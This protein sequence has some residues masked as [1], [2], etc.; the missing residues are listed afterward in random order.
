MLDGILD[1]CFLQAACSHEVEP[2]VSDNSIKIMLN[3]AYDGENVY[4]SARF[5]GY[6][7][8]TAMVN[9][10]QKKTYIEGD[11]EESIILPFIADTNTIITIDGDVES[12]IARNT[13]AVII[14]GAGNNVHNITLDLGSSP[15]LTELRIP[16]ECSYL[17]VSSSTKIDT[18]EYAGIQSSIGSKVASLIN[19]STKTGTLYT[20]TDSTQ[21]ATM[22]NAATSKG[23]AIVT[24]NND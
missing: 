23:W 2:V 4:V 21:Y 13:G 9:G 22:A 18:I 15:D 12:L 7:R 10:I 17:N 24:S 14:N 3:K 16:I 11:P 6:V 19:S 5:S 20:S 1:P 8:V